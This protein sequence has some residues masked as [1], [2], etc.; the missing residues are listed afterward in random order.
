MNAG[1]V[2]AIQITMD[3]QPD[4]TLRVRF[5]GEAGHAE[6]KVLERRTAEIVARNAKLTV[7]DLSGMTF[8]SS[9]G[10][11]TLVAIQAGARAKGNRVVLSGVPERIHT[12]LRRCK[13]DGQ[14]E[15]T[16]NPGNG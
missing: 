3:D 8:M 12:V 14:F 16:S 13:L 9:V 4:G 6:D 2:S 7:L 11:R 10:V 15:F 5:V 1:R